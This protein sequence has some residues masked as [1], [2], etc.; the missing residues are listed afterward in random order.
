MKE[1]SEQTSTKDC[2]EL[3][4]ER[5]MDTSTCKNRRTSAR[6]LSMT[7]GIIDTEE[8][9]RRAQR[10]STMDHTTQPSPQQKKPR[11][12]SM[13]SKQQQKHQQMLALI[14]GI[15]MSITILQPTDA[16]KVSANLDD[17][18]LPWETFKNTLS[19]AASLV[20]ATPQDY[21]DQ[22]SPEFLKDPFNRSNDVLE[23]QP[24]G[25]CMD[26]LACGF[27]NCV[28][29]AS[30]ELPEE[31]ATWLVPDNPRFNIPNAVLFPAVANDIVTAV[32]FAGQH[33][34]E[35]SVKN[36][37]HNHAGASTKKDTLLVN[38]RRNFT[39]YSPTGI[40]ECNNTSNM[41][42]PPI[43]KDLR[44]QPC[45]LALARNKEKTGE[46]STSPSRPSTK[47]YRMATST[48]LSEG[49]SPPSH[50]WDGPFRGVWVA[51]RP[52][53]STDLGWTKS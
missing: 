49:P 32:K 50:P 8:P 11:S 21:I 22:C 38:M 44:N 5:N 18:N 39:G 13:D 10:R 35:L 30:A 20:K 27:E 40:V 12:R 25:V 24:S 51:Q 26:Q 28:P 9:P 14:L 16:I 29:F 4:R 19:S 47:N 42:Q 52:G 34:L 15:I 33:N 37:G 31:P 41:E 43:E 23:E 53:G 48:S 17:P 1:S 7:G 45:N 3:S 6:R 2:R 46:T 36:S